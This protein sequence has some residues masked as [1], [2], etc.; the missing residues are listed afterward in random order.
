[1]NTAID[2]GVFGGQAKGI[3]PHGVQHP[4][5][6]HSPYPRNH[7]GDGVVADMAHVQV[8]GRIGKHRQSIK[9]RLIGIFYGPIKLLLVPGL[10]PLGFNFCGVVLGLHALSSYCFVGAKL[11]KLYSPS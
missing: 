9:F 3:P 5:A 6:L 2:G 10:L 7:I 8:P 1:M 11:P 4:V